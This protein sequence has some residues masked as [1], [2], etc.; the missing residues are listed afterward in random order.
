M[1]RFLQ[2]VDLILGTRIRWKLRTDKRNVASEA[3]KQ[4]VKLGPTFVK[5]GQYASTRTDVFPDEFI[6]EFSKLQDDVLELEWDTIKECI[7]EEVTDIQCEPMASASLGQVH[8]G[9]YKG[10]ECVVKVLRPNVREQIKDDIT[11]LNYLVAPLKVFSPTGVTDTMIFIDE[12]ETML[13]KETDYSIEAKNME[14]FRQNFKDIDWVKI[15][16]LYMHTENAIVMEYVPSIKITETKGYNRK[17]LAYAI[18]KSQIM[19]VL[20]TGF[21]HGDPHPGNVGVNDGKL[22]Y[23]DFGM[24]SKITDKQKQALVALLIAITTENE[25]QILS[26]LDNLGLINSNPNGLRQFVRFFLEYIRENK[27]DDPEQIKELVTIQNNPVKLS[28]TFFY[29]VRSFGLIEG[30]GKTLDPGY[31]SSKILQ[32]YAKESDIM[33]EAM[34]TSIQSTISDISGVS[35]K[36]SNLDKRMRNRLSDQ[37]RQSWLSLLLILCII[38]MENN[39]IL[40]H[41]VE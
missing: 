9:K 15:P 23:Y 2:T 34:I 27:I 18:T 35:Y 40:G 30:I 4:V 25:D 10:K 11:N 33:E 14:D 28:G 41:I 7:P 31:S 20:L 8:R 37:N 17:S 6:Q 32:N 29:L 13:S 19:Q 24:V 21:F 16:E 1:S 26:I 5:I 36:I 3:R 22:V 12:L 39:W 38:V